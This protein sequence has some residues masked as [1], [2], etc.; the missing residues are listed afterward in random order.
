MRPLELALKAECAG[1]A[2]GMPQCAAVSQR[3]PRRAHVVASRALGDSES[4]R[5]T[6]SVRARLGCQA[7]GH[8]PRKCQ[9]SDWR[10][11]KLACAAP[12]EAR[13]L[14]KIGFNVCTQCLDVRVV[15]FRLPSA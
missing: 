5:S 6:G 3:G 14:F 11:R 8:C 9:R 2:G 12:D 1:A 7:V 10:A 4:T 15:L 13:A